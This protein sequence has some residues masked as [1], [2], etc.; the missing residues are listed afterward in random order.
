M[1]SILCQTF[2]DFELIVVDDGSIDD[3]RE[4]LKV[5]AARDHRI[6]LVFLE[7]NG[8]ITRA[9]N[10][11]LALAQ[12]SYVARTDC[13][14]TSDPDRLRLQIRFLENHPEHILVGTAAWLTDGSLRVGA[15][16]PSALEDA[17]IRRSL[18]LRVNPVIHPSVMFRRVEGMM[19]DPLF[20][21]AEDHEYWF[22]MGMLG[23]F[24]ILPQLLVEYR[25]H[26]GISWQKRALQMR[27][28]SL[29]RLKLC[30]MLKGRSLPGEEI[31]RAR[32]KLESSRV[33]AKRSSRYVL[34][35][36]RS[37]TG[38]RMKR[39]FWKT[40]AVLFYPRALCK[41]L[42]MGMHWLYL[43]LDRCYKK[44]CRGGDHNQNRFG[45]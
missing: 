14:D 2:E 31:L 9:L 45:T 40:A 25:L 24:A 29:A 28:A 42:D 39:L 33:E 13:G 20:E 38:G 21:Y 37:R 22:R 6:R 44:W 17:A 18:Y 41:A 16:Q 5:F 26:A 7:K 35:H 34:R 15:W 10:A 11:G 32:Q 30:R 27:L 1:D 3:T 4:L 12:G 43:P 19:Y 23:K 8:G 36:A